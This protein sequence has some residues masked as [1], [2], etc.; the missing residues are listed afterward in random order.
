M[1]NNKFLP[2]NNKNPTHRDDVYRFLCKAVKCL[3]C[4]KLYYPGL[5]LDRNRPRD[6]KGKLI[7]VSMADRKGFCGRKC[8]K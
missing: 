5:P 8:E 1:N 7:R 3:K 6:D 2:L 4:G